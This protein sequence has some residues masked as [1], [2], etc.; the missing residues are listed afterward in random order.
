MEINCMSHTS[1]SNLLC[2]N[3]LY[4]LQACQWPRRFLAALAGN[5]G[6]SAIFLFANC[7]TTRILAFRIKIA[8]RGGNTC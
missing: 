1:V 5:G 3:N 8:R 7:I 6:A 2:L 4:S